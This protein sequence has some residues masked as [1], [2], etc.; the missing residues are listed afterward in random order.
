M[1]PNGPKRGQSN[2]RASELFH[3][4]FR[5]RNNEQMGRAADNLIG[6]GTD[7]PEAA[8]V[9]AVRM[10]I[11]KLAADNESITANMIMDATGLSRSGLQRHIP[12][13]VESGLLIEKVSPPEGIRG[14]RNRLVWSLDRTV[15]DAMFTRFRERILGD[16]A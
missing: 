7:L 9:S 16:D 12:A 4:R 3:R 13:L 6:S 11:L 2:P 10:R 5:M 14:A 15:L 1:I 8:G